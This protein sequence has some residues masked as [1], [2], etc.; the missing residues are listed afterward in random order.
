MANKNLKARFV[1]NNF[2]KLII[3]FRLDKNDVGQQKKKV[4]NFV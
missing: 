1:N 3:S 2:V 4:G